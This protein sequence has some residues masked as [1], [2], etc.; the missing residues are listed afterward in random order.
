VPRRYPP[1][2]DRLLTLGAAV[3]ASPSEWRDYAALGIGTEHVEALTQVATELAVRSLLEPQQ[4]APVHAWRALGQLGLAA[5]SAAPALIALLHQLP[6]DDWAA[7]DLR[8]VLAMLG[9]GT[10]E[11]LAYYV[12]R[13]ER[14]TFARGVAAEAIAKLA[15]LHPERRADCVAVLAA[16]LE[17]HQLQ[18]PLFNAFLVGALLDVRAVEQAPLIEAAYRAGRVDISMCGDWEDMQVMLGLI[19]ERR[20]PRPNYATLDFGPRLARQKHRRR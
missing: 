19:P 1:P 9:P 16:Q 20:T 15:V 11:P 10:L 17:R 4:W 12:A 14:G 3:H 13:K 5:A 2:V 8:W 7:A 6:E 18:P